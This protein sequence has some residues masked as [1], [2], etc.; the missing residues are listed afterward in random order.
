MI[1]KMLGMNA[2]DSGL[3]ICKVEYAGEE[4]TVVV[5]SNIGRRRS[6]GQEDEGTP[7]SNRDIAKYIQREVERRMR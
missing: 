6:E 5:P 2:M 7:E 1:L 3:R 4:L